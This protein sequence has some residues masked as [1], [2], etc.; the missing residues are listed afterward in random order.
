MIS[1]INHIRSIRGE[2]LKKRTDYQT[3]FFCAFS[4]TSFMVKRISS[5]GDV[6]LK[7]SFLHEQIRLHYDQ[8]GW[9][10][11]GQS[12]LPDTL[13][14]VGRS[15]EQIMMCL[16]GPFEVLQGAG[17]IY[18][19]EDEPVTVGSNYENTICYRWHSVVTG[20]HLMLEM[21]REEC[22]VHDLGG[23]G[24]Y[25][26]GERMQGSVVLR[27]GDRVQL[28]GL[29]ILFLPPYLVY[30]AYA[31]ECR[32]MDIGFPAKQKI[33]VHSDGK[34]RRV[35]GRDPVTESVVQEE[36]ELLL[37]QKP[38]DTSQQPLLLS[39]G[40]SFT[41]MLP[42]V[43]MGILSNRLNRE[44]G[45]GNGYGYLTMVTGICSALL[46]VFW[47]ITN[48]VC[49]KYGRRRDNRGRIFRYKE[50]LGGL[51]DTLKCSG[52]RAS[53]LLLTK[54]P[55]VEA[56]L[57]HPEELTLSWSR[58]EGA[59]DF[60]FTRL[61]IG[62]RSFPVTFKLSHEE[63][64]LF[65]DPL[66]EDVDDL[67]GR[68]RQLE[69]VP[70]GIDLK[71]EQWIGIVGKS[72]DQQQCILQ[73]FWQTVLNHSDTQIR[74]ICFYDKSISWQQELAEC[75]KW[76]PHVWSE[77]GRIR[78]LAG[79]REEA[80][81]ILPQLSAMLEEREGSAHL[82]L[83]LLD[84]ELIRG[85]IPEGLL[86]QRERKRAVTVI[87]TAAAGQGPERQFQS[88]IMIE[89]G[90]TEL[91]HAADGMLQKETFLPDCCERERLLWGGRMLALCKRSFANG[92]GELPE[93]VDFLELFG[94]HYVE[95]LHS[96]YRWQEA[97]PEKRLKT[98][99]G[100]GCAKQPVCLDLHE[101]FHGPHG[102]VAG[103]TGSGK[104]ELLQTY[105]LS[106]A[107]QFSPQDINFLMIDYKGGGT[108][109][110]LKELP[111]C[112]G[113]ISNL[114]GG[115][116][117]RAMLAISSE[118][119]RRQK[120]FSDYQVNHIDAYTGLF[121]EGKASAPLPHL[122]IVMDEFAELKREEPEFMQEVI[123]LAQVGRSLG[124]HLIL[125]TQKPSGTVDDKIWS[126]ARFHLC[127]RVQDR[128]DSMDMLHKPDAAA[129]TLPGQCYMQIGNDELYQRF[130]TAYC[131]GS[132]APNVRQED[133]FLLSATGKRSSVPNTGQA[134][135][136]DKMM[137]II[138]NYVNQIARQ[139]GY[140]HAKTLWMETLP[141]ILYLE[142]ESPESRCGEKGFVIGKMD[143][144]ENQRQELLWY[145]SCT[146]GHMAVCGGPATGKT[147]LLQLLMGQLA[148]RYTPAEAE[149]VIISME[150]QGM[151]QYEVLPHCLGCLRESKDLP[152]FFYQWKEWI[153]RRKRILGGQNYLDHQKEH[154]GELPW[155]YCFVDGFGIFRKHLDEE[156]EQM[157]LSAAAEGIGIGV[158]LIMTGNA[159]TDFPSK[160]WGKVKT[161]C[162]LELSDHYQY[163]DVLR[164]YQ[165]I[166]QL[167]SGIPGRGLCRQDKRILEFQTFVFRLKERKVRSGSTPD[168]RLS[169]VPEEPTFREM[170]GRCSVRKQGTCTQKAIP[171]GYNRENGRIEE[172]L[173]EIAPG[174]LISG[175][176]QTGK[177]N[178][179]SCLCAAFA[180]AGYRLLQP[181]GDRLP[182]A[183]Q[184]KAELQREET[185]LVFPELAAFI[186]VLYAK[187]SREEQMF[188]EELA[189][190]H[191]KKVI[192]L[193]AYPVRSCAEL[194]MTV[195]FRE[196]AAH[197][198][199]IHLG[200]NVASQRALELEDIGFARMNRAE[201]P[202]FGYLKRGVGGRS[203]PIRIPLY[204]AGGEKNAD[205][206]SVC[207]GAG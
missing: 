131:G 145:N 175:A 9:S 24:V 35:I 148:E 139:N 83:F 103:T 107:V 194:S 177:S 176:G 21:R 207:A 122:V 110:A 29:H 62:T 184:L 199:G 88:A 126:N 190:G 149:F 89:E 1:R 181:G 44:T 130:Q 78:F 55:S 90:K 13:R 159:V 180:D 102:L 165:G 61:G 6:N 142:D 141:E 94:C 64:T 26:N 143:D 63:K 123:S 111:H 75:M 108:G 106:L 38:P 43:M 167:E 86:R 73:I 8:K 157:I 203:I 74:I 136:T 164:Q 70:V 2:T 140:E 173:P 50:Y 33:P 60:L 3:F 81:E 186:A 71:K 59:E 188:W 197:Q 40:P 196:L 53:Q 172:L 193:A 171:I 189:A 41:M 84:P 47:G 113:V 92:Q 109:N 150:Q 76:A 48:H 146:D 115:Q 187:G 151:Q 119:K 91:W 138:I 129:L 58:Y 80:S 10:L 206:G 49:L 163:G 31:G 16:N 4:D 42:L 98:P 135:K 178:L 14:S 77:D 67:L 116:I 120:I 82:L 95:E 45:T 198:W 18:L 183:R 100:K 133:V 158:R 152:V 12:F 156:Q 153:N 34:Q 204:E 72:A 168:E 66:M 96:E 46:G 93:K 19:R 154:P 99:I 202:G 79:D 22:V 191:N 201:P 124:V 68:F 28:Y 137:D 185:V 85:E 105:L 87:E 104:S 195:F 51:S 125:A 182:D 56:C 121:R 160:L 155:L 65:P 69:G 169:F 170:L 97:R 52:E 30:T 117:R 200:G 166:T 205:S 147:T 23:A 17:R 118:N 20:R 57:A 27:T 144:P 101:K 25:R 54:Y 161:T 37:P 179:I 5:A 192:W 32:Q 7:F 15:G 114:S 132:Y 174:L 162:S 127:L 134:E 39:I 128:Q 11:N 36:M 112:A